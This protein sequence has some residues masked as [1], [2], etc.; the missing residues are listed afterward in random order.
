MGGHFSLVIFMIVAGKVQHAMQ[1]E[2]LEFVGEC[3]SIEASI[4]RGN[5]C[6]DGDI[7]SAFP[8]ERQDI[9]GLVLLAKPAVEFPDTV[10]AGNQDNNLS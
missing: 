1:D 7:A 10:I 3:M 2:D 5:F 4:L 6:R 8:R 9:G